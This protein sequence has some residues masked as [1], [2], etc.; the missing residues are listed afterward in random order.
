MDGKSR[1]MTIKHIFGNFHLA[2]TVSFD[3]KIVM[4]LKTTLS[5]LQWK[6]P[7]G[8]IVNEQTGSDNLSGIATSSSC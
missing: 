1:V 8:I 5:T 6:G 7:M 3:S 2:H 4:N